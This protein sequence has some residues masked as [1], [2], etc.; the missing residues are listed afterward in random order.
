M[1]FGV[2]ALFQCRNNVLFALSLFCSCA[3]HCWQ[4]AC[5]VMSSA[6]FSGFLMVSYD[7]DDFCGLR[8]F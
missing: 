3:Y 8:S 5:G 7:S 2:A 1:W 6:S 4:R